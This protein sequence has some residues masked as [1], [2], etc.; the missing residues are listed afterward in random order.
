MSMI[1]SNFPDADILMGFVDSTLLGYL[2][3][4]RGHTHTFAGLI[5]QFFFLFGLF[6]FFYKIKNSYIWSEDLVKPVASVTG[7]GLLSH[8][9][10]D[11]MNSYG[12]HPFWPIN[13]NWFYG[14]FVFIIE[15]YLWITATLSLFFIIQKGFLRY[16]L[17]GFTLLSPLLAY[18]TQMSTVLTTVIVYSFSLI[19][20]LSLRVKKEPHV[21]QFGFSICMAIISLFALQS[22]YIKS[23]I[24]SELQSTIHKNTDEL[25]I[26]DLSTS[27]FPGNFFCWSFLISH[28]SGTEVLTSS[29]TYSVFSSMKDSCPKA[30]RAAGNQPDEQIKSSK[31]IYFSGLY[32]NSLKELRDI[33]SLNC[34]TK[35]W[36]TYARF[37]YLSKG[38]L[39]DLRF[40]LR[41]K[42]SF[43]FL[44]TNDTKAPCPVLKS[45]WTPP[46][47][48]LLY[49]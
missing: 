20:L 24:T 48:N 16:L 13:N 34:R 43:A 5:L 3:N 36:F 25:K 8:I 27:P 41:T 39:D 23:S 6:Y 46:L 37:P 33:A 2:V 30:L 42:R 18:Y 38:L 28:Q 19:L 4:H 11:F 44:D 14:D 31:H 15:P 17:L 47:K 21:A 9:G 12:V 1:A 29:G 40:S 32:K 26:I 45:P 10:L 7:F 49:K 22:R 35:A